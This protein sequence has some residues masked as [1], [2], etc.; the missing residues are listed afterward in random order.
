MHDM[1]FENA[2]TPCPVNLFNIFTSTMDKEMFFKKPWFKTYYQ[3]FTSFSDPG[4][5]ALTDFNDQVMSDTPL[6]DHL[7]ALDNWGNIDP[8]MD[9]LFTMYNDYVQNHMNE[10]TTSWSRI[11]DGD[12]SILTNWDNYFVAVDAPAK[13]SKYIL[14]VIAPSVAEID[15]ITILV[16][17]LLTPLFAPAMQFDSTV[18]LMNYTEPVSTATHYEWNFGDGS[19]NSFETHPIH[20]FPAFD[21]NYVVC[22]VASNFCSS[23]T[24]CD[25]VRI[26]SL[27]QG[28]T[29]YTKKQTAFY[30]TNQTHE[31]VSKQATS[32]AYQMTTNNIQLSNYPNPFNN[33]TIID[34]EIW[35]N[36]TNAELRI[37]NVLG[38][39]LFTQKLNKPI[40]KIQVD[41]GTLSNGIYYYSIIVDGTVSQTRSMSVIH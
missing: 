38:Q 26:D 2:T 22:L 14:S 33:S 7:D 41:G 28:G 19:T 5:P 11:T 31:P 15:E 13:S 34:Y 10:I 4:L 40:D 30:E 9:N 35:Q 1:N 39:T 36:Y 3:N 17:T 6:K 32:K 23:F 12:T 37:T 25:T 27:H 16:D 18:Y 24:F 20:T 29:L 8:C 21:S